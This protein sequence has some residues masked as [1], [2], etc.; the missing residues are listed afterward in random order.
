MRLRILVVGGL[1]PCGGAGVTADA[2]VLELF[3]CHALT[4]ASC[5][6]VQ[7]RA[8]F[9]RAEAVATPTLVDALGVAIDDGP[10][11]AVKIGLIAEAAQLADICRCLTPLGVPVLVDPVLSAT[12]GG[13]DAPPDLAAAYRAAASELGA[14]LTPNQPELDLLAPSGGVAEL[15][16]AGCTAVVVK[17]G[18]GGDDEIVDAVHTS[19][20]VTLVRHPRARCGP[21]HGTGCAFGAA[22]AAGLARGADVLVAATAASRWVGKCLLAMGAGQAARPRPFEPLSP[23][24]AGF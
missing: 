18:H 8:G 9:V 10:L 13:F 20:G 3:E 2:R 4:V 15:L 14:V 23:N 16:A 21:V 1:D 7:S 12:A 22:T 24:A 11:H 5:L 6:T 17:G 19:Q